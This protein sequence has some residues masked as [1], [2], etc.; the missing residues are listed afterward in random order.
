MHI[1]ISVFENVGE[2]LSIQLTHPSA[3]THE[4][5]PSGAVTATL[6]RTAPCLQGRLALSLSSSLYLSVFLF[7]SLCLCRHT[8]ASGRACRCSAASKWL[9][10]RNFP[11]RLNS[12]PCA[13]PRRPLAAEPRWS[14]GDHG[15]RQRHGSHHLH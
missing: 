11:Q 14:A 3:K 15:V 13:L 8:L 5:C 1:Y 10:T 7:I 4:V 6:Q 2:K 12:K 9:R